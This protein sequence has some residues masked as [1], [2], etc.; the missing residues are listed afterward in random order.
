MFRDAVHDMGNGRQLIR[1]FL[2]TD[3]SRNGLESGGRIDGRVYP[4]HWHGALGADSGKADRPRRREARHVG[5]DRDY[6]IGIAACESGNTAGSII[7]SSL[8][9]ESV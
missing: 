2:Q 8:L 9:S 4:V 5:G 1:H 3:R 7:R 6:G